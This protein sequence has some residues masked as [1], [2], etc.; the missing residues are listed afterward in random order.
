MAGSVARN[1]NED[2]EEKL[3][4]NATMMNCHIKRAPSQMLIEPYEKEA[5]GLLLG[6]C[7]MVSTGFLIRG[8]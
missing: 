3:Q 4:S 5:R 8:A 7:C 2:R 1:R 6:H